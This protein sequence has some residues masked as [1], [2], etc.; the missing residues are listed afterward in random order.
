MY[1]N[2]LLKFIT[3]ATSDIYTYI[4]ISNIYMYIKILSIYVSNINVA[5]Y[6]YF[7]R[8]WPRGSVLEARSE[9]VGLPVVVE[10]ARNSE[11]HHLVAVTGVCS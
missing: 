5:L 8:W 6:Y 4:H 2:T 9:G 11:K 1:C 10:P 7:L 3:L